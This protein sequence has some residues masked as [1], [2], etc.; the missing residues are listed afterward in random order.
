MCSSMWFWSLSLSVV[1]FVR[2]EEN[3]NWLISG[4]V[5]ASHSDGK[6]SERNVIATSVDLSIGRLTAMGEAVF[7]AVNGRAD[8]CILDAV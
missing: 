2:V 5:A 4:L 3:E 6:D 8:D 7:S 1:C